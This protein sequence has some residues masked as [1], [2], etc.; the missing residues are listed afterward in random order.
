MNII[1]YNDGHMI[2]LYIEKLMIIGLQG[3]TVEQTCFLFVLVFG[4][5]QERIICAGTV[6]LQ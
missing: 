4:N 5:W 3:L 1:N 2:I 6:C